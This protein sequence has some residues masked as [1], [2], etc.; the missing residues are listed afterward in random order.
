MRSNI[1]GTFPYGLTQYDE[2]EIEKIGLKIIHTI[3]TSKIKYGSRELND[4]FDV[5]KREC[6][7]SHVWVL[8]GSDEREKWLPFQVASRT[9]ENVI[10]EI[11]TDFL[12][13]TPYDE[14]RDL[15]HWNSYFYNSVM[16][17]K[18]GYDAKC[19]K[20]KKMKEMCKYLAIAILK[21]EDQLDENE[22]ITKYQKKECDIA[23]EI[24]PLFWNPAGK[25]FNYIKS[26]TSDLQH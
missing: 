14:N 20:Y 6:G 26:I 16:E 23:L 1:N 4:L 2:G 9:S 5:V 19:Q 7:K 11:R 24:K 8:Y 22:I 10:S 12:C 18:Y 25:E 21:D 17:V 3:E 15:K 13:M